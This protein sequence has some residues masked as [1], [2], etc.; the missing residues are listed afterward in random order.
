MKAPCRQPDGTD[1]PDRKVGCHAECEKY[2]AFKTE[3][4]AIREER[5]KEYLGMEYAKDSIYRKRAF[6]KYTFDG[7][8]ALGQR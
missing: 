2:K 5:R 1:C 4:D 3:R 8:K 7:K 6:L